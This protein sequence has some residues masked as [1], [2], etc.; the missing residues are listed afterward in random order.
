LFSAGKDGVLYI[1]KLELEK[2]PSPE[3]EGKVDTTLKFI[4]KAGGDD[5]D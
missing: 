3:E 1:Y 5:K 2:V 4:P